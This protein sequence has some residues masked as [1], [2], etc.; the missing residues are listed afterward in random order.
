MS[1]VRIEDITAYLQDRGVRFAYEG[2]MDATVSSYCPLRAPK[3]GCITWVRHAE[4]ADVEKLNRLGGG[5]LLVAELGAELPGA[6][7]PILYAENAHRT[8]FRILARFFAD[9][10]P[11]I[12][13]PAIASTAVVESEHIGDGVYIGHYSHIGKDVVIGDNV[14]ILDRVSVLGRVLIGDGTVIESGA[15]IGTCGYGHYTDEE[16]HPVCVPHL[17]GVR[18]G[19][20]V[21]IGANCVIARGCLA[22][23][24][25]EDYAK[26]DALSHIAHNVHVKSCAMV[27]NSL[28]SGSATIGENAWLAPGTVVNTA[29]TVGQGSYLGLGTV[30]TKDVPPGKLAVGVPARVIRDR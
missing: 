4:D 15:C 21:K 18:I 17:G 25:I 28:V 13:R 5:I 24:V 30:V 2:D 8:F 29:A 10:D 19:S 14:Q 27:I 1:F 3:A 12:R 23:T 16:S 20:Q 22:D 26:I 7:F 6:Q 11:E 9:E